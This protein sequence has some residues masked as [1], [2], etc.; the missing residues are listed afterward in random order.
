LRERL[1]LPVARARGDDDALE[2]GRQ[3]FGVEDDDV[4]ALYIFEPIDD[5]ALQF[6]DVQIQLPGWPG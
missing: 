3:M 4:V 6:S 1:G 5:G 2:Q